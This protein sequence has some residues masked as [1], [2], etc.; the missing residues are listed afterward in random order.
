[1]SP[2]VPIAML[3]VAGCAAPAAGAPAVND[4]PAAAGQW[5]FRPADGATSMRTPPPFSWRPQGRAP[6]Y[7][8][9]VARDRA[10][11]E[12]IYA[13]E[14]IEFNVHCPTET[15]P[16]GRYF[17]R[18]RYTGINGDTSAWSKVRTFTIDP[19]AVP[20][21][22]PSREVLLARVP[23][24]H[25][26]LFLRPEDLPR[27]RRL[28][29]GPLA[30][31]YQGLIDICD[32]LMADPPPTAE[33][34]RY[35]EGVKRGSDEWRKIWWGNRIY[36]RNLLHGAATLGFIYRLSGHEPYGQ[37][38]RRLLMAAAQWDPK[39]STS[40]AY[41]DEAAM[42]YNYYFSR[43]YTFIHDLLSEHERQICRRVMRVRGQEM[44]N[45]LY[46]RHLWMPYG[47]HANRE[48]HF[49][50]EVAIAFH[51]EIP[52]AD[53]WL[54]FVMN[55]FAN[56]YPVWSDSDGGWHEG[57]AYW[58][59]Y[60]TRFTWWADVMRSCF[61][62]DAYDL[63]YFS[64]A[65]DLALY[66]Q[67]P[68]TVGGGFGDQTARLRSEDNRRLMTIL[69]AQAQN[70]YWAWY[71]D[72]IGGADPTGGYIGFVRDALPAVEPKAPTDLPSSRLFAGVG[73][74][75]LNTDLTDARRNVEIIFKSSP[76]GSV[77]HGYESQNSFLLYAFG[78][79]LFIRSGRRDTYGSPHHK[80]WMWSTRSTNCITID[81]SGQIPHSWQ[82]AG[83]ISGF[84]TSPTIDYVQGEAAGAYEEADV[85]QFTRS[86]LFIKPDL[87]VIHDRLRTAR[88]S[89]FQWWLHSPV[90]MAIDGQ[91]D[92][93][94]RGDQASCDAAILAPAGL[95][96]RVTD[97]FDPPPA[98]SVKLTEYHL[99]AHTTVPT[100]DVC[101]VT[102]LRPY[103]TG[104]RP[105]FARLLEPIEGGWLLR[106]T[107]HS[108]QA[109]ILLRREGHRP[110]TAA[111]WRTTGHLGAVLFGHDGRVVDTF[112][113]GGDIS[114]SAE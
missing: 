3:V 114:P 21:P 39:G 90:P 98:P 37:L 63:P 103:R 15:F 106:A 44:Y 29:A 102:V 101:F 4:S 64:R 71:V 59:S 25:P 23:D 76:F 33:P 78:D 10:F 7:A 31:R 36:T 20:L 1:M 18:F 87:I 26:R 66:L 58:R 104:T 45:R 40:M 43:T 24:T 89:T 49:L 9:Q 88:A 8:L 14:G 97:R 42:P 108:G 60:V 93:R 95:A 6:A 22:L 57:M 81:G 85:E 72:R 62:I 54:W 79:R 75:V 17:W 19:Q 48:W 27:L 41:N 99:T 82:A 35:P 16:P 53:D 105:S 92:I 65:G 51:D 94:V 70:P 55:V 52:E 32:G 73:Q 107:T 112:A 61:G 46:P 110:L 56:V 12:V 34:P 113:A 68:G 13:A 67:P 28:A 86:I 69:A 80:E 30:K 83:R 109:L 47:S 111:G 84:H 50:G 100:R 74:A 91:D 96:L 5:G 38:A 2:Y 77:S 11:T